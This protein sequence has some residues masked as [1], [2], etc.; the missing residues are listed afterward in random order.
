MDQERLGFEYEVAG[1]E[2]RVTAWG[3]LPLVAEVLT[4][5]GVDDAV[6]RHVKMPKARRE[7]DAV[8]F[9]K[10]VVLTMAAGGDCLDDVRMLRDDGALARL[11][12][13]R[14]PSPESV[15]QFLYEFHDESLMEA[16]QREAAARKQ[17]SYVPEESSRL[18]GLGEAQKRLVTEFAARWPQE[19]ATIDI[20]ATIQES[21][22]R[23]AKSH[24]G[25]GRGYQ[26]VVALWM[27]QDL[28]VADEFR[29]GNVPAHKDALGVLQRALAALPPTVKT[30][31]VRGDS[32][33]CTKDVLEW[34]SA[35]NIEFAVGGGPLIKDLKGRCA[36]VP[37]SEWTLLEE[38]S[39]CFVHLAEVPA[40]TATLQRLGLRM[41]A[42]RLTPRQSELFDGPWYLSVVTNRSLP[43]DE[44]VRW[45]WDKAGTIEHVHDVVKNELGGG[46]LPCGRFGA[47]AAWFRLAL[48][49]YNAL[50]VVRQ[51]GPTDLRDAK[52]KR[53]RLNLLALPAVVVSHARQL[54]ARVAQRASRAMEL[55]S[56]RNS[57]WQPAALVAV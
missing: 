55:L 32:A 19:M 48:L 47:N 57:L 42:V 54:L 46:V 28:V 8:A 49:T 9:V 29:D 53:L 4:A 40:E 52:P 43:A 30:R 20:D 7:F 3:G 2:D 21:H 27:E 13:M 38:R 23:E 15:R 56:A 26:P 39:D 37:E 41:V 34:L 18:K 10:T 35:E 44:L 45:Y 17:V 16:A 14:I 25:G 12:Q 33:M 6:A 36:A 1:D 31:R 50:R 51:T 22:K 24:Y 11:L 5:L